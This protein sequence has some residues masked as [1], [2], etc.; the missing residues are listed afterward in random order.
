MSLD[1]EELDEFVPLEI[2][3]EFIRN[4]INGFKNLMIEIGFTDKIIK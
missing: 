2:C 3:A 1:Q 4:Y